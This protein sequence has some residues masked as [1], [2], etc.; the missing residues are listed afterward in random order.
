MVTKQIINSI[1]VT[2][3]GVN[4]FPEKRPSSKYFSIYWAAWPLSRL[5]N[6]TA[7]AQKQDYTIQQ[8]TEHNNWTSYSETL[9][10]KQKVRFGCSFLTL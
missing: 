5:F 8:K 1:K 2:I 10:T 6:F 4:K 7:I 3:T 9:F